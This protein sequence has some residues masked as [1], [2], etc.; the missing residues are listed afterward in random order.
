MNSINNTFFNHVVYVDNL[1]VKYRD[2]DWVLKGVNLNIG[3]GESVLIVGSSGGGKTTLARALCGLAEKIFR[4]EIKGRIEICSKPV[5]QMDLYELQKCIQIVNQDPYT[6]FLEPIPI[7][8]MIT[9]AEG[10]YG[11]KSYEIVDHVLKMFKVEEIARKPIVNLSG[12]QLRRLAI[13][14][15]LITDPKIVVL[16]EPLMWLDDFDGIDLVMSVLKTLRSL[17][18]TVIVFEHRFLRLLNLFDNVY[19]LNNGHLYKLDRDM[20]FHKIDDRTN[21]DK[22]TYKYRGINENTCR[23]GPVLELKDVWF[24]YD[25]GSDWLLKGVELNVCRGDNIVI[26]G[27]NGSGKSTLLRIIA[28]ILKPVRGIRKVYAKVLYVPQVPYLFIT[29]D[30]V[31][32]E[33]KT[34]CRHTIKNNTC[35][36]EGTEV[37]KKFGFTNLDVPPI[38]LSWG[39]QTR[40]AV[41]LS[42]IASR[43][44]VV[45]LDEPFTGS[46]YLDS[47]NIVD[48]LLKLDNVAKIITLSSKDYIPLFKDARTY[49]LDE[50]TLKSF[51]YRDITISKIVELSKLIYQ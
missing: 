18:K 24:R 31:F 36:N 4:V 40:L 26:Y 16:D 38:N 28:G 35:I 8:D 45:I 39:Q 44:G 43:N 11:S 41:L 15:A 13:A 32:S 10:I 5:H 22:A 2:S 14:K 33:V 50:G 29:E 42:Y 12:G 19:N 37:L 17:K 6:H 34:I 47:F 48:L 25:R 49:I 27:R 51:E 9:Y 1:W 7:E 23:E 21:T 46:T 20:V 30:S 3:K